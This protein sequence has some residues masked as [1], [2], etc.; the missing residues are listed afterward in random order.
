MR[1]G[2][3]R[4]QKKEPLSPPAPSPQPGA[5]PRGS[6]AARPPSPAISGPREKPAWQQGHLLK[7][8]A[9]R[10]WGQAPAAT[11]P[12]AVSCREVG[13]LLSQHEHTWARRG[14]RNTAQAA[15]R[16]L[17]G[18]RGRGGVS[19]WTAAIRATALLSDSDY[20]AGS[21][22]QALWQPHL[23]SPVHALALL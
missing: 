12:R 16:R 2:T 19:L 23:Q 6:P 15:P 7:G 1:Q 22:Y 20:G 11:S 13:R 17:S 3:F 18:E 21:S 8:R 10:S 5:H 4:Q 9:L 14:I